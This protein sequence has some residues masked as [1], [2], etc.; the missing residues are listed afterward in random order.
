MGT[1]LPNKVTSI[2]FGVYQRCDSL[3]SIIIPSSVTSIGDRSFNENAK[4]TSVTFQGTIASGDF[5]N[6]AFKQLGDLRDK[7]YASNATNG[8]SGTYTTTSPVSASS[9]WVLQK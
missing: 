3:T 7:F 5:H 9:V 1:N 2:G 6:D 8:T 4:L